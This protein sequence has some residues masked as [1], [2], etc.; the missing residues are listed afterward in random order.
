MDS[1]GARLFVARNAKIEVWQRGATTAEGFLSGFF[2]RA[3]GGPRLV[4]SSD[5]MQLAGWQ[6]ESVKVWTLE[7]PGQTTRHFTLPLPAA[8]NAAL[9]LDGNS[10]ALWTADRVQLWDLIERK[11]RGTIEEM[12]VKL[13]AVRFSGDG[14]LLAARQAD[15][16]VTLWDAAALRKLGQLPKFASPPED[17]VFLPGNQGVLTR[18]G[19]TVQRWDL[20]G[21]E[22]AKLD[23]PGTPALSANG[24]TLV[25]FVH[26]KEGRLYDP[27]TFKERGRLADVLPPLTGLR[28]CAEGGRIFGTHSDE[29]IS[30]WDASGKKLHLLDCRTR[31]S[32]IASLNHRK[33]WD[34]SPDGSRY[35]AIEVMGGINVWDVEAGRLLTGTGTYSEYSEQIQQLKP[36]GFSYSARGTGKHLG[37]IAFLDDGRHVTWWAGEFLKGGENL[38]WDHTGKSELALSPTP[39]SSVQW[40]AMSRD[41]RTLAAIA[42]KGTDVLIWKANPQVVRGALA[43]HYGAVRSLTF[44]A[45]GKTLYSASEDGSIRE[46]DTDSGRSRTTAPAWLAWRGSARARSSPWNGW[47]GWCGSISR[48]GRQPRRAIR[49]SRGP[50]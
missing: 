15:G 10:L 19:R 43:G 32:H 5:G 21:R 12:G 8:H 46:W 42:T 48:R 45:D 35:V 29:R 6:A 18:R 20:E 34:V 40:Q 30:V 37:P 3:T 24:A 28:V 9:S 50:A 23:A 25:V 17:I 7:T 39:P 16:I 33:S 47:A 13:A 22:Q 2:H 14:R 38:R 1:S 27:L 44:A 49:S 4:L 41:G 36:F 11:A 26:A 31:K